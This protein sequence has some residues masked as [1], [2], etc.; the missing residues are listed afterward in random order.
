MRSTFKIHLRRIGHSSSRRGDTANAFRAAGTAIGLMLSGVGLAVCDVH[1]DT[2]VTYE[3][4]HSLMNWS[5]TH[6]S[7]PQRIFEPT[8]AQQVIRLLSYYNEHKQKLRPVGTALSPNG[9]GLSDDGNDAISLVHLDHV[10]VNCSART[11]TVGAG[12]TVKKILQELQKSNLT[13]ENFSSIQEQQLAGWTQVAAH[14]TGCELPTVEEQ[15]VS[16]NL[17]TPGEGLIRLSKSSHPSLFNLAKVGLGCLGVVTEITL[18]CVPKM[19]LLEETKYW[20][21]NEISTEHIKRLQQ[22]RHVRYMWIPHTPAV[23][24]V[25]SNIH[26]GSTTAVENQSKH[27]SSLPMAKMISLVLEGKGKEGSNSAITSMSFTQLRD[28]ALARNPLDLNVTSFYHLLCI[29]FYL[30]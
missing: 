6:S 4:Q 8:S 17:A 9:I 3:T 5:G 10:E 1:E 16:M 25:C 21:R 7:H 15:I 2:G 23:I 20:D 11:V 14:G 27:A 24:S 13:L 30:Y 18:R 28:E 22:F 19:N 12:A 26:S 29:Y